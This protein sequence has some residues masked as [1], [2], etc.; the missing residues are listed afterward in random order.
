LHIQSLLGIESEV[1]F[2]SVVLINTIGQRLLYCF[3][4]MLATD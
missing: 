2:H 3:E 4:A 1:H